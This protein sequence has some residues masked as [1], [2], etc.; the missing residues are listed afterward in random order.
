MRWQCASASSSLVCR[1]Y[2]LSCALNGRAWCSS[3]CWLLAGRRTLLG[4]LPAASPFPAA[5]FSASAAQVLGS[6]SICTCGKCVTAVMTSWGIMSARI[7]A[8]ALPL[9]VTF[10]CRAALINDAQQHWQ[11]LPPAEAQRG[12]GFQ[13]SRR[14][15]RATGVAS[16]IIS[17]DT[18]EVRSHHA[19]HILWGHLRRG[20]PSA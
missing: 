19:R 10:V 15:V 11:V 6:L 9:R 1:A 20:L 12:P 13:P 4:P 14:S 18:G 3:R 2:C 8:A 17:G 5:S 16:V 7:Q